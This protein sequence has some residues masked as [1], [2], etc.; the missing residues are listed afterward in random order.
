MPTTNDSENDQEFLNRYGAEIVLFT[1]NESFV[2]PCDRKIT[3]TQGT[4]MSIEGAYV[5]ALFMPGR[6]VPWGNAQIAPV[7]RNSDPVAHLRMLL[8]YARRRCTV[9]TNVRNAAVAHYGHHSTPEATRQQ[10][11]AAGQVLVSDF[12]PPMPKWPTFW[13]PRP[14]P[15]VR[16]F[17]KRLAECL[18]AD[19]SRR[20]ALEEEYLLLPYVK[21]QCA[22]HELLREN[23][24]KAAQAV[25]EDRKD[26]LATLTRRN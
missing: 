3:V 4:R 24:I 21:R 19:A 5:G 17:S 7:D 22:M 23:R 15:G 9:G 16:A 12:P 20:D 18:K 14:G 1:K 25:E 26:I 6:S 11:A 10:A 13:A 2:F 8:V